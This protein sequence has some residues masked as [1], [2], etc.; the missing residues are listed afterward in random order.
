MIIRNILR[1]EDVSAD[2]L[3]GGIEKLM[4]MLAHGF[5]KHGEAISESWYQ[6]GHRNNWMVPKFPQYLP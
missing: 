6:K 3:K 1:T 2:L 4:K 5:E